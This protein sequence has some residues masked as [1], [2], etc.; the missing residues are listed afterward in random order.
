MCTGSV[1]GVGYEGTDLD[2]F[3]ARLRLRS[4]HRVVDVRLTPLSRK[5][6][7]S[8]NG[9]REALAAVGISYTHLRAL[10]NPKANR[11]GFSKIN[12][13]D[14]DVS[15]STYVR[16]LQTAEASAALDQVRAYSETENIALLCFE[17][18]EAHCHRALVLR[19]LAAPSLVTV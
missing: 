11:D 5:K 18:E 6:G 13:E 1:I 19:A 8:K 9:L 15:R 10:G 7:F 16:L 3:V 17:A 14:A 4:V 12:G 2:A